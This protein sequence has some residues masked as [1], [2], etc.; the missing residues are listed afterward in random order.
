MSGDA[1]R[2]VVVRPTREPDDERAAAAGG[3]E[4]NQTA[5]DGLD[6]LAGDGQADA[7]AVA[8]ALGGVLGVL[9]AGGGV[10][11]VEDPCLDV[12]RDPGVSSGTRWTSGSVGP[13]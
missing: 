1:R 3:A 8:V 9:V 4:E 13:G 6:D 11:P 12:G 10:E 2:G 5:V 7:V